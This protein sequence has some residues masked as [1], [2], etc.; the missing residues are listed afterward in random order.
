[1]CCARPVSDLSHGGSEPQSC[2]ALESTRAASLLTANLPVS[3]SVAYDICEWLY[4]TVS[5][6]GGW[7]ARSRNPIEEDVVVAA[8]PEP[9]C[10]ECTAHFR[11]RDEAR[12]TNI[13]NCSSKASAGVSGWPPRGDWRCDAHRHSAPYLVTQAMNAR[14]CW[15]IHIISDHQEGLTP[16]LLHNAASMRSTRQKPRHM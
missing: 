1:M 2:T 6:L 12:R 9:S 13:K 11:H 4:S 14:M 8:S 16:T 15:L 7:H 3:T 5:T 10:K